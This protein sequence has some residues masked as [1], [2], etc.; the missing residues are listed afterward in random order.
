MEK[1]K[2]LVKPSAVRPVFGITPQPIKVP[3]ELVLYPAQVAKCIAQNATVLAVNDDSTLSPIKSASVTEVVKEVNADTGFIP[4]MSESNKAGEVKEVVSHEHH[5]EKPVEKH[6]EQQVPEQKVEEKIA[7]QE[8]VEEAADEV[9]EKEDTEESDS[10]ADEV[11]EESEEAEQ[12]VE[13]K[14]AEQVKDNGNQQ[15][16][17]NNYNKN[18]KKN[19]NR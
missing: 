11:V 7:E 9:E 3:M 10:K 6:E 1:S 2:Y 12:K 8:K 19:R 16:N 4:P 18:N 14:V 17:S 15:R 5:E 13:E